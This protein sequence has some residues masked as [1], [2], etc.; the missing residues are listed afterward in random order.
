MY[1]FSR[2]RICQKSDALVVQCCY[3][4]IA[5]FVFMS[6]II[7]L[8]EKKLTHR[9]NQSETYVAEIKD[10]VNCSEEKFCETTKINTTNNRPLIKR[11]KTRLSMSIFM[12]QFRTDNIA[13]VLSS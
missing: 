2:S 5:K 7:I 1:Y 10:G 6:P 8:K 9:H 3:Y 11:Q 12:V 13:N 4:Q